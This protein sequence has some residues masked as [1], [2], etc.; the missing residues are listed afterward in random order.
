MQQLT[1]ED[2]WEVARSM[3]EDEGLVQHHLRSYNYF[4]REGLQNLVNSLGDQEIRLKHGT[5]VL[6]FGQVEVGGPRMVEVDGTVRSTTLNKLHPIETRLRDLT[7]EAPIYVKIGLYLEGRL[8]TQDK[9]E[10]GSIPVMVKS[11]ICPLSKMTPD[12]LLAIGEDPRDPGGYF[13]INGSER[14]VVAVEDLAPNRIIVTRKESDSRSQVQAVVL[15]SAHGRQVRVEV[16]YKER[17]P[18][19]VYFSRIYKGVPVIIM[20]RALGMT[21]DR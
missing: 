2:L 17:S 10:V 6:R 18:I 7:Y 16:N 21:N 5:V 15:S 9:V 3:I 20:L 14:V 13:I 4:V 1:S 12:E 8:I 11:D 19:R